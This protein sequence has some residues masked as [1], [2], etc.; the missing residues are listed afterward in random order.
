MEMGRGRGHREVIKLDRSRE[1]G[2]DHAAAW[3]H[4]VSYRHGLGNRSVIFLPDDQGDFGS[5]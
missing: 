3:L 4:P 1:A 5:Q 2:R